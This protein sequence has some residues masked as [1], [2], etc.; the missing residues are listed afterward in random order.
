MAVESFLKIKL[1]TYLEPLD[2][3]IVKTLEATVGGKEV[4]F[5]G[6]RGKNY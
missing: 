3:F 2:G 4:A 1:V 5:I 6:L